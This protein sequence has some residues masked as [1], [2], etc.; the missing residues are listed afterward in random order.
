M[1]VPILSGRLK[2]PHLYQPHNNTILLFAIAL[3]SKLFA[4]A[5]DAISANRLQK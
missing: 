3:L 1:S 2:N 4:I 5:F